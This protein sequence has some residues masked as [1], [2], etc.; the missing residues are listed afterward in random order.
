[1]CILNHFSQFIDK[2]KGDQLPWGTSPQ[3]GTRNTDL[4]FWTGDG[5]P[6]DERTPGDEDGKVRNSFKFLM[7]LSTLPIVVP[8]VDPI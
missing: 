3:T 4:I 1:M 5:H 2:Y 6:P 8:H 7:V